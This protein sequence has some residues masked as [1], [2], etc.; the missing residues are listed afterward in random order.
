VFGEHERKQVDFI[1]ETEQPVGISWQACCK[2]T[3]E[4]L[5]MAPVHKRKA[6]YCTLNKG[7]NDDWEEK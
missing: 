2:Q 3:I 6:Y 5:G 1:L 7:V 4:V